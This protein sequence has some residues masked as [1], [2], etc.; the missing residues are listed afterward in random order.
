MKI[1]LIV[2]EKEL[3]SLKNNADDISEISKNVEWR[4]PAEGLLKNAK[5]AAKNNDTEKG[6]RCLKAAD[7][8]MHFGLAEH[9]PELLISKEKSYLIEAKDEKKGLSKWRRDSIIE[10]LDFK[11]EKEPN[12]SEP[13]E[14]NKEIDESKKKLIRVYRV[15]EAKRLLDEHFDNVYQKQSIIKNRLKWLSGIGFL[16]IVLW[17]ILYLPVPIIQSEGND[18]FGIALANNPI[19]FWLAIV[20]AGILGS[21]LSSFT[22]AIGYEKGTSIP[23]ELSSNVLAFAR[24]MVGALSAIVITVFLTAEILNFQPKNY[25]FILAVAIVSGFSDRFLISAIEKMIKS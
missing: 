2:F 15:I 1:A 22:S 20:F 14:I 25:A 3:E 11:E 18:P 13:S 16:A 6:W 9:A 19:K 5:Q 23:S 24:L 12:E 4:S 17:L 10:L 7:R 8:F 21:I